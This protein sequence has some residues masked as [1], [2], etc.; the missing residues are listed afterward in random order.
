MDF[1][2]HVNLNSNHTLNLKLVL[3]SLKAV[4]SGAVKTPLS[5]WS[6]GPQNQVH[7]PK[8]FGNYTLFSHQ[9]TLIAHMK[10]K[11][12]SFRTGKSIGGVQLYSRFGI[13]G[14]AA[15][16]GKTVAALAYMAHCKRHP[17][18]RISPYLHPQSQTNFFSTIHI[19]NEIPTN[20]YIVPTTE[21]ANLTRIL[22][23]QNELRYLIIRKANQINDNLLQEFHNLDLIV[24]SGS[25][26]HGFSDFASANNLIFQRTF[27][28]NINTLFVNMGQSSIHSQFTW[29]ITHEWFNILYP[30]FS[31]FDYGNVLDNMIDDLYS[32]AGEDFTNYIHSQKEQLTNQTPSSRSLFNQFVSHHPLRHHLLL[33]TSNKYL[34]ASINPANVKTNTI[35]YDYDDRFSITYPV[36][37]TI[38]RG[39]INDDD[40]DGII[41]CIGANKVSK[42]EINAKS[43]DGTVDDECPICCSKYSYPTLTNCCNNMFCLSCIVNHCTMS[44]TEL[45]PF[46]RGI[47]NSTQFL[48]LAEP[49]PAQ[50][51]IYKMTALCEYINAN[52]NAK[53]LLYFPNQSRLGKLKTAFREAHIHYE[54][55]SGPRSA[56]IKKMDKFNNNSN[57]NLL[58]VMDEA[59]LTGQYLPSVSSIIFYPEI[60]SARIRNFFYNRIHR[61]IRE[62][63]L[64][65]IDFSARTLTD[66]EAAGTAPAASGVMNT[67]LGDV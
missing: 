25:Q 37:S 17:S 26:Y 48:T 40:Y 35:L 29:L 39:L 34:Q 19:S 66:A 6:Q 61:L 60:N 18:L 27:F 53:I 20:L 52:K 63:P 28:E 44:H 23:N 10:Q 41:D 21:I 30:D 67:S 12:N 62:A 65:V 5:D 2:E 36:F 57:T 11:E 50:Q 58:I 22:E 31:L 42:D 45:C 43:R 16:T 38:I 54:I 51:G 7:L 56:N 49:L 1:R 55:L 64:T 14:D 32:N 8:H 15:G 3:D 33:L 24:I 4:F 59:T 9:N 47:L 13:L 46:C